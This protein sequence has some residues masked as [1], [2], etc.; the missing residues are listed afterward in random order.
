MVGQSWALIG[1]HKYRSYDRS[2]TGLDTQT[3][4]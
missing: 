1:F 4:V 3:R 2:Q